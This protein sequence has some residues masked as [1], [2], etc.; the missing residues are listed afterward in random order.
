[1]RHFIVIL[2]CILTSTSTSAA[3]TYTYDLNKVDYH[4]VVH[5]VQ[6]VAAHIELTNYTMDKVAEILKY[7]YRHLSL[8][9]KQTGKPS[10]TIYRHN[11]PSKENVSKTISILKKAKQKKQLLSL[12]LAYSDAADLQEILKYGESIFRLEIALDKHSVAAIVAN[13]KNL[14]SLKMLELSSS[15]TDKGLPDAYIKELLNGAHLKSLEVLDLTHSKIGVEAAKAIAASPSLKNLKVLKIG[16][17]D[18]DA[19]YFNKIEDD[20]LEAIAMSPY[21]INLEALDVSRNNIGSRGIK[22]ITTSQNFAHLRS[23]NLNG[24]PL[25][26]KDIQ[27]LGQSPVL[28]NLQELNISDGTEGFTYRT[29]RAS[30]NF[31]AEAFTQWTTLVNLETLT[32]DLSDE[33]VKVVA[34]LPCLKKLKSMRG[35]LTAK[36]VQA[37][38]DSPYIHNL[39][40]LHIGHGTGC[41]NAGVKIIAESKGFQYLK[42]L[43][44]ANAGITD[45]GFMV[46]A[47]S[48]NFH[49]L[50]DW[51]I[52]DND[53]TSKGVIFLAEHGHF[54]KLKLMNLMTPKGLDYSAALALAKSKA[55]PPHSRWCVN[56]KKEDMPKIKQLGK[57]FNRRF[58]YCAGP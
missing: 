9:L 46:M 21:L 42:K 56:F 32:Y 44:L 11:S 25:S 57:T 5:V 7:G 47:Q 17:Y 28:E 20:G 54:P 16:N 36:G 15:S 51:F 3:K 49:H 22:A 19:E 2:L 31:G 53:I 27:L 58:H 8:V 24:N 33:E 26:A 13:A 4:H 39:E 50:E 48:K 45:E 18:V 14:E 6:D 41:G 35:N 10:I 55:S 34:N 30:S 52:F 29:F 43:Y 40:D 1:M 12:T 37:L 38:A 23:L